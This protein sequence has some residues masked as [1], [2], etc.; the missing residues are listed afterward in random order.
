MTQLLPRW[1]KPLPVNSAN[2]Q[3]SDNPEELDGVLLCCVLLTLVDL[4][5]DQLQW[6]HE[7]R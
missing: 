2:Q 6:W 5:E 1:W 3:G 4:V 7:R